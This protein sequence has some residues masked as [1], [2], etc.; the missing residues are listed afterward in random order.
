MGECYHCTYAEND[1]SSFLSHLFGELDVVANV[2][3]DFG[4]EGEASLDVWR[5]L[6]L[7]N[8]HLERRHNGWVDEPKKHHRAHCPYV[9]LLRSWKPAICPR[10]GYETRGWVV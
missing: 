2:L 9:V 7:H 10:N 5:R 6:L 8:P 3:E 1:A 4:H